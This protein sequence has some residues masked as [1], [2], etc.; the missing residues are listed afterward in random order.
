[1][2]ALL[3]GWWQALWPNLVA[4]V[5]AVGAGLVWHHR[6]TRAYIQA[7]HTRV[8]HLHNKVDALGPETPADSATPVRAD[9]D[10]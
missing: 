7:L 9:A 4:D 6:R 3:A 2:I 5:V 10:R 8:E 1:M